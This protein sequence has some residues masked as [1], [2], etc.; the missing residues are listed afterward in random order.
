MVTCTVGDV[1]GLQL[2]FGFSSPGQFGAEAKAFTI[3]VCEALLSA[4]PSDIFAEA[5]RTEAVIARRPWRRRG[6]GLVLA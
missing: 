2:S 4:E 3:D 5:V 1:V 6:W